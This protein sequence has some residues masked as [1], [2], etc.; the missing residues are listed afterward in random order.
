MTTGMWHE[1]QSQRPAP[2]ADGSKQQDM[3]RGRNHVSFKGINL[4][5]DWHSGKIFKEDDSVTT[6]D[7]NIRLLKRIS[8]VF[9]NELKYVSVYRLEL[10]MNSGHGNT[11]GQGSEPVMMF[12]CSLDGGNTFEPEEL[13]E[14]GALGEYDY[15]VQI[16]NL[17]TARN[18][19]IEFSISDPIDMIVTQAVAN[20]AFG[21]Y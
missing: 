5:G 15:R 3:F 18:W 9:H 6:D 21:T 1:R 4:F 20:G 2:Y 11:T 13:I 7:G 17:G 16:N 19:V 12:R 14:L 10:D 8:S